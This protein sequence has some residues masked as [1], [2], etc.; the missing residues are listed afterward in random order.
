MP[1]S[2]P[3]LLLVVDD[4][5]DLLTLYELTLSKSGHRVAAASD[6]A[7]ARALLARQRF[8]ALI[9]DM[10]LPDGLGLELV[11]ELA[12]AGR[13]EKTIV[14]TA[15]G[16]AEN[17]V[18]AL[19]A[20][21]FDYLTK[22]VEPTQLRAAVA[23]ALQAALPSGNAVVPNATAQLAHPAPGPT[24]G[25]GLGRGKESEPVTDEPRPSP[26]P[27]ARPSH[28]RGEKSVAA[29]PAL[30]PLVGSSPAMCALR[31]RVQRVARS[32]A[33]VLVLGESGT[34]KE[35]VAR[36]LHR[37]SHRAGGPFIA[38]NCG[39]IP[40]TLLEAEFFGVRKGAYTGAN[41][42]REGYFQAAAGGT[43]F[44]DEIGDLPLPMQVKLL[45]AVQERRVRSLGA[46]DDEATD[47]RLVSATHLDLAVAVRAG[48]FRQDL[49]YRLNVIDLQLPPLRQRLA[50]LPELAAALL[51][52]LSER[53]GQRTPPVLSA[54]ALERLAR[55][56]FP[57][58]VREL[59]NLL[60]RALA[61]HPGPV[62]D[63]EAI[64]TPPSSAP[65]PATAAPAEGPDDQ[66]PTREQLQSW[67]NQHRWNQSRTARHL[68]WTLA[69]LRYWMQRHGL[70]DTTLPQ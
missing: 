61:L 22:P 20:G 56:P 59:E 53:S 17:A 43:L 8:D 6:L 64:G 23:N 54:A 10:R 57:G 40:D 60:E 26:A 52:R 9:T 5:P 32:M 13:T 47:V 36:A 2:T 18:Q 67:L 37:C 29:D 25:A 38:V 11:R 65:P 35:L 70:A 68:G 31:E 62:L 3:P 46:T 63:A 24:A 33:P 30:A 34:G 69:K 4:E 51:Q 15:Y 55:H 66:A 28:D 44:L 41:A 48:R 39:A 7:Q 50:D 14:V 58:N 1:P 45:R 21:A 27:A 49:Y 42:H 12:Q 19:K 16:S